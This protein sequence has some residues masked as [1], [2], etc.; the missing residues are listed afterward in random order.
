MKQF[1][2]MLSIL[3]LLF[4]GAWGCSEN[5]EQSAKSQKP[6]GAVE[7][8]QAGAMVDTE[9]AKEKAKKVIEQLQVAPQGT[10]EETKSTE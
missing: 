6:A 5:S 3:S 1:I 4:F 7:T 8:T 10:A 9:A 2:F